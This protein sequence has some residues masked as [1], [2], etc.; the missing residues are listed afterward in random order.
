MLK[1]LMAIWIL[2]LADLVCTLKASIDSPF[3]ELNPLAAQ[4]LNQQHFWWIILFKISSTWTGCGIL[5]YLRKHLSAHIG[6]WITILVYCG[7]MCRW[8]YFWYY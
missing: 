3:I 2:C 5:W 8:F 1:L 6:A 7:L 4:I